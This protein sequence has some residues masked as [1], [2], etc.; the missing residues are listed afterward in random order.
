MTEQNFVVKP[1]TAPLGAEIDGID[2]AASIDDATFDHLHAAWLEHKVLFFR[3][4]EL[5][6]EQHKAFA[7]CFG[8]FQPPGFV[9]TLPDHPEIRF[10]EQPSKSGIEANIVWH[11]DDL[12]LEVPSKGSI[13]WAIDVPEKGGDT[14]WVDMELAYEDL[15]HTMKGLLAG[16]TALNVPMAN[17]R[18]VVNMFGVDAFARM[19][20]R[21]KPV[22]HPVVKTHPETGHTSLNINELNTTQIVGMTTKESDS[23]LRFLF[24]H[25]QQPDYQC[26]FSWRKGSAAFWDNR[27]TMHRG[28]PNFTRGH[29]LMHRVAI[30]DS[31]AP[32]YAPSCQ[33]GGASA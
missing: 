23:L 16:L 29:R 9:P 4:Q 1:L 32:A 13:L 2:L 6:P 27:C 8:D 26:R 15:S 18:E 12:F 28:L 11:S 33:A 22:E 25:S 10:Q 21:S 14:V 19:V 31:Q 7:R 24:E 20:K 3:N 30:A 5:T 17:M